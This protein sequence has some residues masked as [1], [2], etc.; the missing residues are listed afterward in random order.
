MLLVWGCSLSLPNLHANKQEKT[1]LFLLRSTL[2]YR[3]EHG[4]RKQCHHHVPLVLLDPVE[5]RLDFFGKDLAT[6]P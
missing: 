1:N 4:Q 5:K 6:A 3:L 2:A